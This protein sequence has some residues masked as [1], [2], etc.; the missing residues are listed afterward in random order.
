MPSA[1]IIQRKRYRQKT[2]ATE[3]ERAR[4]RT[5]WTIVLSL[6]RDSSGKRRQKWITVK[7]TKKDAQK[8]MA[9]LLFDA[10]KAQEQANR[11]HNN[12]D[13]FE[14]CGF[15]C[16]YC[17]LG[18]IDGIRLSV[19]H[20]IPRSLGGDNSPRNRVAACKSCNSSKNANIGTA[21]KAAAYLGRK[22]II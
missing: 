1:S 11:K 19:D 22:D 9:E 15:R 5:S 8:R 16:V 21:Y 10:H 7:G 12:F 18:P 20:I 13:V 17:G 2:E 6:G 3:P 14:A 4:G